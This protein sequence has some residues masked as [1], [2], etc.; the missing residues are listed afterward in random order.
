MTDKVVL[1]REQNGRVYFSDGSS[2]SRLSRMRHVFVFGRGTILE[3]GVLKPLIVEPG[4]SFAITAIVLPLLPV[5]AIS[6]LLPALAGI[7]F[8]IRRRR[9]RSP[10][11]CSECGYNLTGN[12]SGICPECGVAVLSQKGANR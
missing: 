5:A 11:N 3:C 12:M 4:T 9:L 2:G 8:A 10:N 7:R 1:S 6:G